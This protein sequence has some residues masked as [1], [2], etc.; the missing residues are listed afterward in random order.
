MSSAVR[1]LEPAVSVEES[2]AL[3]PGAFFEALLSEEWHRAHRYRGH[4]AVL[5]VAIDR[6]DRYRAR[7]D[8]RTCEGTRRRIGKSVA[9]S[10]RRAGDPAV[11]SGP[12]EFWIVLPAVHAAGAEVV[13]DRIVQNVALL[14]IANGDEQP[15]TVSVGGATIRPRPTQSPSLLSSAGRHALVEARMRG[16]NRFVIRQADA[17]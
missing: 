8:A 11:C 5:Y 16:G 12:D 6:F 2:K 4:L 17:S 7:Y 9:A 13:A 1:H 14:K 3:R 10:L 15:L